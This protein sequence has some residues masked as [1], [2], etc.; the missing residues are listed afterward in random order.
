MLSL[1]L[2]GE[3]GLDGGVED[4]E[5]IARYAVE[6][7]GSGEVLDYLQLLVDAFVTVF[8]QE[9]HHDCRE[10][11]R[12]ELWSLPAD[13]FIIFFDIFYDFF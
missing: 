6:A 3:N 4:V 13:R 1:L 2:Q 9:I 7:I 10:V 8:N 12:I 11:I 5:V